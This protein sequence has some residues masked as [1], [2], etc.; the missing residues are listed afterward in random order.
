MPSP[1]YDDGMR[2]APAT[3]APG[4]VLQLPRAPRIVGGALL[5]P[6]ALIP[7]VRGFFVAGAPVSV[8]DWLTVARG[9]E[10]ESAWRMLATIGIGLAWTAAASAGGY[11]LGHPRVL[12][13]H[14]GA[15]WVTFLQPGPLSTTG[16]LPR[17]RTLEYSQVATAQADPTLDP[18]GPRRAATVTTTDGGV[19]HLPLPADDGAAQALLT[20][21]TTAT[22]AKHTRDEHPKLAGKP[23][24]LRY[25]RRCAAVI[26]WTVTYAIWIRLGFFAY[27]G[28]LHTVVYDYPWTIALFVVGGLVAAV[29]WGQRIPRLHDCPGVARLDASTVEIL[30]THHCAVIALR[31]IRS[32]TI[33]DTGRGANKGTAARRRLLIR[34]RQG[35]LTLPFTP[36]DSDGTVLRLASILT[37]LLG[38]PPA[39]RRAATPTKRRPGKPADPDAR[40]CA[41]WES[42]DP[43]YESVY[44]PFMTLHYADS[45]EAVLVLARFIDDEGEPLADSCEQFLTAAQTG[46]ESYGA[47]YRRLAAP[48]LTATERAALS[49][50]ETRLTAA[51]VAERAA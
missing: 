35:L 18:G 10:G 46:L 30:R 39:D 16:L 45:P 12:R 33:D 37:D 20:A 27:N 25:Q 6:L 40:Y 4:A 13:V 22:P 8:D 31:D 51:G 49:R 48:D 9:Q 47:T 43:G 26:V 5:C 21:M 17:Y 7:L 24:P 11:L 32:V 34:H 42:L 36:R 14:Y 23:M 44:V 2:P 19:H 29:V 28:P 3:S 41:S 15:T 50:L 1:P 38:L